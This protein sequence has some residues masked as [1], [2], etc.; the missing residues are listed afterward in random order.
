MAL[1]GTDTRVAMG[2]AYPYEARPL[3]YSAKLALLLARNALESLVPGE[4]LFAFEDCGLGT[5]PWLPPG[6][7]QSAPGDIACPTAL[8]WFQQIWS[9]FERTSQRPFAGAIDGD[10]SQVTSDHSPLTT[11]HS[12]SW[13]AEK[14]AA[15]VP[16][17]V[18]QCL[19]AKTLYLFRDPRDMYLSANALM[20]E[21]KYFSFGRGPGD[22][23][24]DHARNLAYEILLYFENYRADKDRE[25]C[26]LIPYEDL[27]RGL[28]Q[29]TEKLHRFLGLQCQAE[30]MPQDLGFHRTAASPEKSIDRWRREPLPDG[31]SRF[32]ETY[33]QESFGVFN[34]KF[35]ETPRAVPG[36]EF[37]DP[38]HIEKLV[39][40][41][42][43]MPSPYTRYLASKNGI[44]ATFQ[45][46][47]FA[48]EVCSNPF[49]ARQFTEIWTSL[50][51]P[52]IETVS[53]SWRTAKREYSARRQISLPWYAARH[54]RVLRFRVGRHERWHGEI[55]GLRIQLTASRNHLPDQNVYLRWLRMVE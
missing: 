2:R 15:W 47:R 22:T 41:S 23:D 40:K 9:A 26:L 6:S 32:L 21:R 38:D 29:V 53:I 18:R 14:V 46:G 49:E 3:S 50:Y 5:L 7:S 52:Q 42:P 36:A 16:A 13:H 37:R 48:I 10:Q 31:V 33:L 43:S 51:G 12:P 1:L 11:H 30:A 25:D 54:W 45:E 44:P 35:S 20:R 24:L 28:P 17:F 55:T 4:R 8:E 27:V 19:P 39:G 34:Y